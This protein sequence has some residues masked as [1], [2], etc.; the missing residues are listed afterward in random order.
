MRLLDPDAVAAR[1]AANDS[2]VA[3]GLAIASSTFAVAATTTTDASTAEAACNT[4]PEAL[5]QR[6]LSPHAALRRDLLLERR[7]VRRRWAWGR[8]SR[9]YRGVRL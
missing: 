5:L 1:L 7:L 9:V 8:V 4:F 6:V 3:A 2:T